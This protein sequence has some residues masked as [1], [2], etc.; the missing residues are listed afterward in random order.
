M[1]GKGIFLKNEDYEQGA[2]IEAEYWS[3]MVNPNNVCQCQMCYVLFAFCFAST[4]HKGKPETTE[5]TI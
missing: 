2:V 3:N 1:F 5:V 4:N